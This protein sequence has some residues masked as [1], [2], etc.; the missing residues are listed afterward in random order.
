MILRY[1]WP[2]GDKTPWRVIQKPSG[3]SWGP[4]KILG[5]QI[6]PIGDFD[7]GEPL[8]DEPHRV[9]KT[10]KGYR[11]FYTGRVDPD[12]DAMLNLMK[13]QGA[14][15]IYCDIAHR[16]RY[17]AARIEPKYN[18]EKRSKWAICRLLNE[19]GQR[20]P[21]WNEI[22]NFHDMRTGVYLESDNLI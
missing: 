4:F 2:E 5:S 6:F 22:I 19:Y 20:N 3:K 17:Y 1:V 12:F 15:E 14:D 16:R 7:S 10:H 9:Y 18:Q 13:S 11:V 21:A 8:L